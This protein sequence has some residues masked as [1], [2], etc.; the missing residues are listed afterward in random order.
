MIIV[1]IIYRRARW[2]LFGHVTETEAI[3]TARRL[4]RIAAFVLKGVS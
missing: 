2:L 3:D 4:E 1:D